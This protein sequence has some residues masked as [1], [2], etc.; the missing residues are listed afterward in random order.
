VGFK[1]ERLGPR[2]VEAARS[3][4]RYRDAHMFL[5]GTGAVGGTAVLQML[6]MYEEMFAISRPRPDDV[7]VL[8]AT[9]T[10]S[11]EIQAFTRRLFRFVESRGGPDLLPTKIRRGYL[12]HSGVFVALERFQVAALPGLSVLGQLVSEERGAAIRRFLASIGT[13]PDDA[14]EA[15]FKALAEAVSGAG[16]FTEFLS[17][18]RAEHLEHRGIT[19]FRSVVV[20]IPI[21]S[22]IAYHQDELAMAAEHV[23]ALGPAQVEDL[24]ELFVEAVRDDLVQVKDELADDVLM[25]H[26]TGVGGM[27][28]DRLGVPEPTIRLGFAHAALDRR[29]AEKHRFAERLTE[30]YSSA[31]IKV[32]ITAAAIG[33][34]EVRIRERVPLHRGIRRLLFDSPIEVFPGSKRARTPQDRGG[35]DTRPPAPAGQFLRVFPPITVP[36]GG[37]PEGPVRFA[38]GDHVAPSYAIRS[39]ENGFFTVAD[40]DALYRVM[41]VASASE[42]GLMLASV[43]L[44]GDDRQSPWFEH[45]VCFYQETDNARQVLDFLAQP[46]LRA[47][48]LSGLEPMA[49]QD[50]GSAKHQGEMHTLALLI[51]L[52]RLRTLDVDAV[53]PYV[54]PAAFD[55]RAFFLEHSRALTFEDLDQWDFEGLADDMRTLASA[56]TTDDLLALIP[57]RRHELFP[58]RLQALRRVLEEVLRAVWLPPSLGSPILFE[59]DGTTFVRAGYYV[60]PL[61]LLL[62]DTSSIDAWLR[63]SHAASG[64][65]CSFDDYRDYHVAVGGFV[66]LRPHAI[67]CTGR[68]DEVDLSGKVERF[69]DQA[70]LRA[71]IHGLEPYSFFQAAG[72]LAVWHRL[73]ALYGLLLEA[74]IELGS[75]HEFRWQMPRDS[76]G[77][78]VVVPGVVEAQRMVS[79]GLEKTTGTERLDGVWGYERRVPP[80][81]RDTIPGLRSEGRKDPGGDADA[82]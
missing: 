73:R 16:P 29:L 75:L 51:L 24:K 47:A 1:K 54:D 35:G 33:I 72:L 6:S 44:L 43:A 20:G 40:A 46:A 42:L 64:N 66:D 28:D 26:T 2:L 23:P 68:N 14:P 7:P 49:L 30:R 12:T 17:G 9:G 80:D 15:V 11:D 10:T 50:L 59:R 27:Y 71:H 76:A 3:G 77:H 60:A 74:M 4:R 58:R 21:P 22:L 34:D 63:E 57:P 39:G 32:L 81:R 69:T 31:G 19:R 55:P 48:Q 79:E 56:E 78:I 45:N 67:V 38:R 82:G 70:A 5:G 36:F 65:P 41:R 53:D 18:Y 37:A 25:A 62:T 8:V 61:D 52:H 13:S